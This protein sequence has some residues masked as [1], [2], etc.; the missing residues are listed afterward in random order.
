MT[1]AKWCKQQLGLSLNT[2]IDWNNYLREVCA[3]AVEI[4]PQ[5]KL[6][7][8]RKIVE[9]DESLFSKSKNHVGRILPEQWIS[10]GICRETK[11]SF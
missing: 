8:P 11:E 6:G 4:K 9:I 7:G 10:G 5:T 1:S 2:V 3:M